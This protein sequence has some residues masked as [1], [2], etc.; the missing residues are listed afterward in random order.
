VTDRREY[1]NAIRSAMVELT[2]NFATGTDLEH[3]LGSVTG[4]AVELVEGVDYA[5]VLLI[6]EG[7]FRSVKPTS[8]VA[9]QLD[10]VQEELRQGPCLQ[11][12]LSEA[13]IRCD[14]LRED[15]RW[16]QF[17]AQAVAAGVH[18]VLSFQLYT[19][20]S[21]AGALN[22]F[23]RVA[24]PFD[25]ESEA[26]GAMLATHAAIALIAADRQHQFESALASRDLIGQAKGIIMERFNVDAVRAFELI[27]RLSQNSNTQ[28]RTIAEQIV[29]QRIL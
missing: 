13:L 4:A 8:E 24:A 26:I 12:A 7:R 5:D 16:P 17:A 19:H 25:G 2:R 18:S 1:D 3:T 20:E 23:G 21:G 14:D 10:N 6:S 15:P 27:S 29:K 28:V 22:L 11:A 9:T